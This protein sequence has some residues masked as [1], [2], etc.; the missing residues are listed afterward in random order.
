MLGWLLILV[1]VA[2][3]V[4]WLM[5]DA[6]SMVFGSAALA[7]IPLAGWMGRATE[8]LAARAGERVGGLLNA[9]FGNAAE[10]VIA[11]VALRHGL[12]DVVKASIAGSIIGNILLVLG[13]AMLAGGLRFQKQRYNITAAR[14]QTAMLWIAAISFVFA[15]LSGSRSLR[16]PRAN[17][18]QRSCCSWSTC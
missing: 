13:A 5:P 6:Q 2:V 14:S 15:G 8:V 4:H 16:C 18:R 9:T 10:L 7:I 12:Y 11:L 1:P 17:R 3:A